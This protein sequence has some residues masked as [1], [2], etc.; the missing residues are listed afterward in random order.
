V[1]AAG[2]LWVTDSIGGTVT[3]LSGLDGSLIGSV[4]VGRSPAS[5]G[6]MTGFA[7]KYL[8]LG[9]TLSIITGSLAAGYA[10]YNYDE[11]VSASGGTAP[12]TWRIDSGALPAG[13]SFS[14][15]RIFGTPSQP[16]TCGFTVRVTDGEGASFTHDYS[17]VVNPT[18]SSLAAIPSDRPPGTVGDYYWGGRDRPQPER[19]LLG[20]S[21]VPG[22]RPLPGPGCRRQWRGC[23]ARRVH[24]DRPRFRT[25][26]IHCRP[27]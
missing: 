17:L 19:V 22:R 12:Y 25:V 14:G 13:L 18:G 6:D 16:G 4:N 11:T 20:D 9:R 8:V 7:L 10:G 27:S 23:R 1:D 15:G 21:H 3:R 24:R 26:R 2:N 5:L